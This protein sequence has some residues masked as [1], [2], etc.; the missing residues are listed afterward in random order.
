[1]HSVLMM[2]VYAIV[3]PI[4]PGNIVGLAEAAAASNYHAGML[5]FR[6]S[7][8]LEPWQLCMHQPTS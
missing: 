5:D 4:C 1:M 6:V 8:L 2:Q 3:I 7:Q